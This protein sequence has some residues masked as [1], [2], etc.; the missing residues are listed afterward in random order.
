M[1]LQTL[2]KLPG[3]ISYSSKLGLSREEGLPWEGGANANNTGH[4][5]KLGF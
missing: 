5:R 4:L 3:I 1:N 2:F